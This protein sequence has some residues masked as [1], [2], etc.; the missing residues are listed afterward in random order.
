MENLVP[1]ISR[2]QRRGS[3]LQCDH[4]LHSPYHICHLDPESP[5]ALS[6][7]H[8]KKAA[9]HPAFRAEVRRTLPVSC[10]R[11]GTLHATLPWPCFSFTSCQTVRLSAND[12]WPL[13]TVRRRKNGEEL[14]SGN[15]LGCG[16]VHCL[17]Y[18]DCHPSRA[19][20]KAD[21]SSLARWLRPFLFSS[22]PVPRVFQFL[23]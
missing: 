7:C 12:S 22:P 21:Q 23:C 18:A 11:C 3:M 19:Y 10:A 9:T 2:V 15:T 5:D 14:E 4:V 1:G 8:L 6:H 16:L 13:T 17:L 20:I